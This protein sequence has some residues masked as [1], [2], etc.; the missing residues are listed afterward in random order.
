MTVEPVLFLCHRIPF[1]PNKGDKI[2]SYQLLRHLAERYAVQ[3]GTFVDDPADRVHVRALEGLC[4]D[5]RVIELAPAAAR[6]RSLA[7]LSR[8]EALSVAYYRSRALQRW[9]D[10]AIE[11]RDVRRCVVFSSTM[12][13]FV[14]GHP[15][16]RT[17]VDF[18][19]VDSVK[20]TQFASTRR[21][22]LAP[23]YRREGRRLLDWER[24]VARRS[25]AAVF[26]TRAEA[27]MFAQLA[28][29]S[30]ARVRVVENG[31]DAEHFSPAASRPTPYG[32]DEV[33]LVFTGAMDYWP[34]VDAVCWFAAEA[35]PRIA[36]RLPAIR[37]Y[38][39]GMKPSPAVAALAR[40]PRI[41]VTGRVPDVRPYVQHARLVVA[42]LRLARGIQNKVLEAMA[43]A[44][45]VLVSTAAAAG[46]G[47]RAGDEFETARDAD[48]FVGKALALL[49]GPAGEA[50]GRRARARVC[51][52]RD[53]TRNL[54]AFDRL[55][56]GHRTTEVVRV[57]HAL[58]A[59]DAGTEHAR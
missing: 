12:A 19:D 33:P 13:Q 55:L 4:D 17:V 48:E 7:G 46:L 16:V 41:V 2:R 57:P 56:D 34:N 39:V 50:M 1:P 29:E 26:A 6:V 10:A 43:M 18:C 44:R 37:F 25:A 31:V 42:P 53:W 58:G 32:A 14:V 59:L 47:G 28:P 21:W 45:P 54:E 22:P 40:D 38:I 20:W 30:A 5:L 3:L 49:D 23:L 36:A 35:L 52:E 8:R 15:G 27:S 24:T 11:A 51:A 9:V